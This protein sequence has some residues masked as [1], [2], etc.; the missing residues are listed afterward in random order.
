MMKK[1]LLKSGH[2]G[3]A[4]PDSCLPELLCRHI[5]VIDSIVCSGQSDFFVAEIDIGFETFMIGAVPGNYSGLLNA[6]AF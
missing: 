2:Q 5:Q 4:R 6:M 3:Y 1:I